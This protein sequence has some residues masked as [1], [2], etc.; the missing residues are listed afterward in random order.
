MTARDGAQ[1]ELVTQALVNFI[2]SFAGRATGGN[3]AFMVGEQGPELFIPERP[4]TIV[5]ADDVEEATGP[6]NVNFSINTIDT[7]GM[8]D[9]LIRQRGNIIG[10]IREA[11]NSKGEFFLEEVNVFEDDAL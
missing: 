8:E 5:P 10:M 6:L 4:G 3:T 9:A 1:I 7:Q 11:A 2:P